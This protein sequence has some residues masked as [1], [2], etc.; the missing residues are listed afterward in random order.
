V[1][2][3]SPEVPGNELIENTCYLSSCDQW[4]EDNDK[5]V[6]RTGLRE[7]TD[8]VDEPDNVVAASWTCSEA[9]QEAPSLGHQMEVPC[10]VQQIP[11]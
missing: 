9:L 8:R 10:L 4:E 1:L 5:C 7:P 11:G 6:I 2:K 3:E